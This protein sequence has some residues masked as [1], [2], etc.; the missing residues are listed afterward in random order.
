ML[1]WC[2]MTLTALVLPLT[3]F[4]FGCRYRTQV[5]KTMRSG[6]RT[7]RSMLSRETWVFAHRMLGKW[8][9]PL[10]AVAFLGSLLVMLLLLGKDEDT[11]GKGIGILCSA[12]T[13]LI[14]VPMIPVER[15]LKENFD[16]NGIPNDAELYADLQEDDR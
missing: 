10:G 5:P 11:V 14:L 8:W 4:I 13:L 2:A 6:Y 7:R 9:T 1:L 15:A 3:M 16:E 12:Q